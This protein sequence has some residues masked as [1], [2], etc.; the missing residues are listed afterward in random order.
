MTKR[1]QAFVGLLMIALIAAGCSSSGGTN[2]EAGSTSGT[3]GTSSAKKITVSVWAL[4]EHTWID[5]A[6]A[7]FNAANP[8][9]QIEVSKYAVDPMKEALK[10]AA[11]SGTLPNM[12]STWGGSLGSFYAE[13]GLTADLTQIA[14]DH[15]W[16]SLYNQAAI[17]MGTYNGK[18][19]GIPYHLN[20]VDMWYSKT[21]YDKLKLTAP[22]TFEEL[23]AQLQ[24]MKDGGI[25]PLSLG[26]KNGWHVMRLTEQ[27][28][29]HFAGPELHDKL[30]NLTASW[31]D[32]AVVQTFAKLKEYN[33]KGYFPKG[34]VALDPTEAVNLFYPGTTGL[35]IDGT[36]L[37]GNIA[38]AGFNVNDFGV[39]KFPTGRSSVFAEMFQVSAD[40]DQATLEATIKV[41]EYL[42]SAEVVNKY[43]DSY[44]TP[45]ALNVTYS[46]NTPH[47]KPLLDM[48]TKGSFLITD[49][50]LP[51]EV[52]Q[53]LFEAQDKVALKEWTP[54][55]AAEGMEK[56]AADYKAKNKTS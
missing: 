31:N 11:N 8:D 56:A 26:G 28:L 21:V 3:S 52:V 55:Q 37:D 44:G 25:T 10:V 40:L 13:N 32:P 15:N 20:A 22:S 27:L 9:I 17:D 33:D 12:W 54:E 24:A 19:S 4:Q 5:G 34:Y 48:A 50:A 39:F 51:Q 46:E 35:D 23:E 6:A 30:N 14:K 47:L 1:W 29:E 16:P 2:S 7:D 43:I 45:A 42:T 41:G 18:V 38:A 53:K 36:W 49:Q